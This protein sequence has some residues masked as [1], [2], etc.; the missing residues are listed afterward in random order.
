MSTFHLALHGAQHPSV[1]D[2]QD[3][4]PTPQG[5]IFAAQY[6][7]GQFA[8]SGISDGHGSFGFGTYIRNVSTTTGTGAA[9]IRHATE[10]R[11]VHIAGR[12]L[13]LVR[14]TIERLRKGLGFVFPL[15]RPFPPFLLRLHVGRVAKKKEKKNQA[16]RQTQTG[17]GHST[18][19]GRGG[20]V[21]DGRRRGHN[22][23]GSNNRIRITASS[24]RF[25]TRA[26]C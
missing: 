26:Q 8:A 5:Q 12:F 13:K 22:H 19:T 2:V 4:A 10:V 24:E 20:Q 17:I 6:F 14:F 21:Q 9:C 1:C 11:P 23:R 3:M 25:T 18:P 16:S 7:A 15:F